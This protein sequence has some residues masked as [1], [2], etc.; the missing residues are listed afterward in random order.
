MKCNKVATL[1]KSEII[2]VGD[3]IHKLRFDCTK[4]LN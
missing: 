4:N 3:P 2:V 1:Y